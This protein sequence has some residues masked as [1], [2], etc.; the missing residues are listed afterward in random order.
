MKKLHF[1]ILLTLF[2]GLHLSSLDVFD[3]I[4][5][6]LGLPDNALARL[7]K[8]DGG[9]AIDLDYSPDGK[10]LA[11]IISG[12][13]VLW[14][15]ENRIEKL[16]I[17]EVNGRYVRYSPDGKT[18]V[19]GDVVYDATNGDPTLLLLDGEGYRDYVL[20]SPD[21]KT[22]AGTG[23]KGVRFWNATTTEK[24]TTDALPVDDMTIDV[25]PT[26][27]SAEDK[28][29]ETS[30]TSVPIATSST[31]VPVIRGMSFSPD[32]KELAIACNLGIWIYDPELNKEVT[33]LTE[34]AG[35]HKSPVVEVVYSPDGNTLAA[36][37]TYY[38]E[39]EI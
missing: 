7:C 12:K 39:N 38:S 23:A 10:T 36:A 37:G 13:V 8:Q 1:S 26:D 27:T 15:V 29:E 34:E 14:D 3:Q 32:G 22:L 16:T 6:Q 24:P 21:G 17:K 25:L 33:L 31:T 9:T 20:F 18:L 5:T 4:C 35:G 11:S 28:S 19:C 30:P 2:F